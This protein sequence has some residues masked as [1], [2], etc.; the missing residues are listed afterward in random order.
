M[1]G[2]VSYDD[3]ECFVFYHR[4]AVLPYIVPGTETARGILLQCN[5]ER[6]QKGYLKLQLSL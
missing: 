3:M 5:R 1:Q 6:V 2:P 4:M